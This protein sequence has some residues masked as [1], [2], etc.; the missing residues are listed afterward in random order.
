MRRC[1]FALALAAI[2]SPL[3]AADLLGTSEKGGGMET[4]RR[5]VTGHD[6]QGRSKVIIDGNADTVL[7]IGF[8]NRVTELW[9]TYGTRPS[10][11]G[12]ADAAP[13]ST[14][15]RSPPPYGQNFRII[16]FAPDSQVD[17]HAMDEGLAKIMRAGRMRGS[18]KG[19]LHRTETV[20]YVVVLKGEA[21]HLTELDEVHLKAGDVLVQRGTYH[22]WS[23]RSN[24]PVVLAV[25]LQDAEPLD[26]ATPE[27][28]QDS[29][30]KE[31]AAVLEKWIAAMNAGKGAAPLMELYDDDAAL[32][33]THNPAL[34][35]TPEGRAG[36]FNGLADLQ[37]TKD[38]N[39]ELGEFVTHVFADSAVNTGFYTFSFTS[40]EG[41]AVVH[42]FRF[43]FVYRKTPH[44]WLIVSHHSSP[45]PERNLSPQPKSGN[46]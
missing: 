3:S 42:R 23:N 39:C 11:V 1:L 2:A 5:V 22:A 12:N 9:A 16:E 25:V 32:F 27:P 44:G 28:S 29:R 24:E 46:T 4:I 7:D 34:L 15:H 14:K 13:E 40:G 43:S 30:K 31:I 37:K 18:V 41:H 36:N 10:N 26:P 45:K 8:G 6:E 33:A 17:M 21:W 38:F 20:D 19:H 35:T